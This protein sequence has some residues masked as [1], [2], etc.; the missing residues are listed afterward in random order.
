MKWM[1]FGCLK[2][3]FVSVDL[4][5]SVVEEQADWS[6]WDLPVKNVSTVSDQL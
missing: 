6:L 3:Y 5:P 2:A 4:S 1:E